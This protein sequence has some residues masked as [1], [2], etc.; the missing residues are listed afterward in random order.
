MIESFSD[1]EVVLFGENSVFKLDFLFLDF[2]FDFDFELYE[3]S[4]VFKNLSSIPFGSF[5]IKVLF[6]SISFESLNADSI[7]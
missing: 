1:S 5:L 4:F 7:I 2:F 3:S 6:K